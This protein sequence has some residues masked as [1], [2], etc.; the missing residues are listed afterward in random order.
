VNLTADVTGI[1]PTANGG[2]GTTTYVAGHAIKDE[3]GAALTQRGNINCIGANIN[4]ADNAVT[5]A[6]DITITASAGQNLFETVAVPLGTAP[7]ADTVT[8]TMAFT[9]SGPITMTGDATT[10]TI[11]V[12]VTEAQFLFQTITPSSGTAPVADTIT[13]TLT[14]NGTAPI[15]VTGDSVTDTIT[16]SCTD[17]ITATAGTA[18]QMLIENATPVPAFTTMSGATTMNSSGV[19]ALTAA[20]VN[21]ASTTVTGILPDANVIDSLTISGG[22]VSNSPISGSTGSF[23]TITIPSFTLGSVLFEGSGGLVSQ[24]NAQFFWNNTTFRLGIGTVLPNSS[25]EVRAAASGEV[26]RFRVVAPGGV[27]NPGVFLKA[28]EATG[29]AT[30]DFSGSSG[31][32]GAIAVSGTN[33]I[34]LPLSNF[35]GIGTDTPDSR[36]Q[37]NGTILPEVTGQNLGSASLK[38]NIFSTTLTNGD[39]CF[40]GADACFTE[41]FRIDGV[42]DPHAIVLVRGTPFNNDPDHAE[43][44]KRTVLRVI[45][46]SDAEDNR[47]WR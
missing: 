20:S 3:G 16:V 30:I 42:N 6:T 25:L 1:L 46:S 5:L 10:D 28:D 31:F 37:V 26:A 14:L 12:A 33:S 17:C 13:D 18:G 47:R 23:S 38:W 19:T 40:D 22:T 7:V 11:A 43:S 4:C 21:L 9:T 2:T 27:K 44:R 8:D 24:N 45:Y 32:S 41:G 36:L 34:A 35:V 29:V 39:S 15:V